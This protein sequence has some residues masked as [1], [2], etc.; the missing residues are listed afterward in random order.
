MEAFYEYGYWGLFFASFLAATILPF[1][2]EA[3]LS[4]MLL[5]G[6]EAEKCLWLASFG[7]WLGGM[8]SYYIGYFGKR[9]WIE[10]YL[11]IKNSTLDKYHERLKK[12]GSLF[13]L[14]CWAPVIGDV[15]AVG[16]GLI[17]CNPALV[18]VFMFTG[19]CLRYFVLIFLTLEG[20]R[21]L[22]A[23]ALG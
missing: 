13:A 10:K 20:K 5:N 2:S 11:K 18:A 19:K 4:L 21:L 17:R 9:S 1:S 8:S 7:N 23:V 12:R 22:S 16:L 6:F 14:L 3:V 15:L